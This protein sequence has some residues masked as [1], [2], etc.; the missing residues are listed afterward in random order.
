MSDKF[1]RC[2]GYSAKIDRLPGIPPDFK[3]NVVK[4]PQSRVIVLL[5]TGEFRE[6]PDDQLES[7]LEENQDLIQDRQSPRKRP[8]RKL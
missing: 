6:I 5:K 3:S 1:D 8:I 7:F 2:G 4:P